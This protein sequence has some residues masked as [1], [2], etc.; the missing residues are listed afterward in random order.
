MIDRTCNIH[1]YR[2]KYIK[3]SVR[4]SDDKITLGRT[5]HKWKGNV[6]ME[7]KQMGC[8]SVDFNWF[9][10]GSHTMFLWT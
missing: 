9:M 3:S 6:K 7:F 1:M 8:E 2:D 5:M 4:Y 10:K